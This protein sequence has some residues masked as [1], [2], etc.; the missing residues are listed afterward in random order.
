MRK[1]LYKRRESYGDK[2]S[3]KTKHEPLDAVLGRLNREIEG[4]SS[5]KASD[6]AI[7]EVN[8]YKVLNKYVLAESTLNTIEENPRP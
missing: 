8:R 1:S 4:I 3:H 2:D 5:P 7:E 6:S